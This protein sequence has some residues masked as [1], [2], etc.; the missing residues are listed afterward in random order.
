MSQVVAIAQ[1]TFRETVR[2]RV[3]YSLLFFAAL[4]LVA[5]IVMQE[6]T[7]GDQDKVVR[8]VAQSAVSV[9][10]SLMAMFLGIGLVYKELERKTIYTIAS[11]PLKRWRFLLGKYAGL[12]LVLAVEV[13]LMAA[14]YC[15]VIGLQQ[16]LP[17]MP[18][19]LSWVALMFELAL[20]TAWA[21][22]FS[23]YSTPLTAS[24]FTLSIFVIGHLAD[25]IWRFGQQAESAS[26]RQLSEVVY[27]ALPNFEVFNFS[28]YAVH[29]LPVPWGEL[30]LAIG[31]GTAYSAAVLAVAALVFENRDFK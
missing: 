4:V 31:Y 23:T 6:I 7:I 21:L 25:D 2:D 28:S 26:L 22:L 16:G 19:L 13:A 14:L 8:S 15:V 27:W 17:G 24:F 5:S 30:G 29:E 18:V 12:L 10:A 3:L 1:N 9:F 20:I 11:K